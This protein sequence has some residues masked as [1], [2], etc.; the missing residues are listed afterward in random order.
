MRNSNEIQDI[1]MYILRCMHT[2]FSIKILINFYF[3][4]NS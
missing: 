2:L 4:T 3:S 1:F